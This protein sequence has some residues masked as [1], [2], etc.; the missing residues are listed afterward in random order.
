MMLGAIIIPARYSSSRF[1]GKPLAM[2][3]ERTMIQCVYE[4]CAKSVSPSK[5]YVATDD[6]RIADVVERFGGQ[7]VLTRKDCLTGTDRIAEAN[8][9]LGADFV[10]NVQGDEPLID[11]KAIRMV[12]D[13]MANGSKYVVNTYST[14][15][16]E[17]VDDPN[18]PKLVLSNT[19]RLL[20]MSRGAVP[21]SKQGLGTAKYKQVCIYGF[22]RA[23]LKIF[24]QCKTKTPNE[25]AEDIEIL[26]FLDLDIPV[27]MLPV[28]SGTIAVDTPEDLQRVGRALSLTVSPAT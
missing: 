17:E 25:S 22:L 15:S 12:Y 11:P 26:R 18:V 27:N 21:F 23:H 3:G 6:K 19:G 13:A 9:S 5:V 14:L 10:V 4:Q 8:E 7:Y 20:Y 1:P 16:D 28:P 24:S 2:I